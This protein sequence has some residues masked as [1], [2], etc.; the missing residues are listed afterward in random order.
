MTEGPGATR[1]AQRLKTVVRYKIIKG[2][3][4]S[5]PN[6]NFHNGI[7]MEIISIGKEVF[8]IY[9]DGNDEVCMRLHFGMNGTLNVEKDGVKSSYSAP[10][11]KNMECSVLLNLS[12][13]STGAIATVKSYSTT[14]SFVSPTT[15]R[16]KY[17]KNSKLDVCSPKFKCE[18]V[19]DG[20]HT[21]KNA[22]NVVISD[23]LLNQE[24][25]PGV[26][27]IIKIESLHRAKMHPLRPVSSLSK[28][29]LETVVM[30]CRNFSMLW[31]KNGRTPNK[32]VY[33]L[34]ICGTCHKPSI[35]MQKIGGSLP[36]VT[37]WC[38]LCQ[39][40]TPGISVAQSPNTI[41]AANITPTKRSHSDIASSSTSSSSSTAAAAKKSTIYCPQHGPSCII[42]RR[43]KKQ[44]TNQHRVFYACKQ[45]SCQFFT[46]AD[47][48]FPKCRCKSKAVLRISKTASSGGKWFF[49]CCKEKQ[50]CGFFLWANYDSH[51][52]IFGNKLTPLL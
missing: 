32:L 37:F 15:P 38:Q 33:N 27:N 14:V 11:R 46:W 40:L 6:H 8:L 10:W 50:G 31:L 3:I 44:S 36:R 12:N 4:L 42:L 23:A 19:V 47:A 29:E 45:S 13:N 24:Y 21:M 41:S 28:R 5:H 7:I 16:N 1:C 49:S 2:R 30:F 34:S 26:G 35:S 43:V 20:L 52:A 39:P 17:I 9:K 18:A 25:F 22:S 51:L 48:H